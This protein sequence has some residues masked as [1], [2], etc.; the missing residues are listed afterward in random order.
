MI[1]YLVTR[2]HPYTIDDYLAFWGKSLRPNIQTLYYDQLSLQKSLQPG[3]YIFSDLERL[4]PAFMELARNA[5][6][7]LNAAGNCVTLNNPHAVLRREPLLRLLHQTGQN[8]FAVFAIND[9][10]S[11]VRFPVF[12]RQHNDHDGSLTTLLHSHQEL[13]AA[14][15]KAR[16]KEIPDEDLLIVEYCNTA[17]EQG[18]FRKYGAFCLAGRIIPRHI[19]LGREWLLKYPELVDANSVAEERDFM[20][21]NPH[22]AQLQE[23][24]DLAH[25]DYG[26][27]DY[28]LLHGRLIT[29]EI[30]TNPTISVAPENLAPLREPLQPLFMDPFANALQSLQKQESIDPI[31]FHTSRDLIYRLRS[32]GG[33]VLRR[34]KL[35]A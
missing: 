13:E 27:I 19:L 20:L 6:D 34:L 33:K 22:T 29:W 14:L 3:I 31:P 35:I 21:Q 12:I 15:S 32:A 9:D 18:I 16:G 28:S 23:I 1:F 7:A 17:N 10:L 8:P 4:N 5:W 11:P 25:I 2:E 24:F 30:N 26:R